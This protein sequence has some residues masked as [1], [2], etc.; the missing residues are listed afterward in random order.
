MKCGI[1]RDIRLLLKETWDALFPHSD[2][3]EEQSWL[4]DLA[5]RPSAHKVLPTTP[6]GNPSSHDDYASLQPVCHWAF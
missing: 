3:A 4:N 5:P 6:N 2:T 1:E